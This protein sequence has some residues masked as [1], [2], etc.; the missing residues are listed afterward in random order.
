MGFSLTPAKMNR[1][2]KE[3]SRDNIIFAPKTMPGYGAFSDT[4]CVRYGEIASL[5]DI[6]F[7]EKSRFTFKEIL[8]PLSQTLFFFTEEEVKEADPPKKGA[9]V[10][11]RSCD[12]H[13]VKRLDEIYLKNGSPD[14]YY[15]RVRERMKFVLMGCPESFENCFCVDMQTNATDAYDAYIQ[16]G[17]DAVLVDNKNPDWEDALA[18]NAAGKEQVFPVF[19]GENRVRVNVPSAVGIEVMRSGMWTEYDSRCIACGRCNFSCPTCTCFTMQDVFYTD[20]GRVGERRRVAASCMVDGFSSVA[21]GG[22]YRREYGQRMR[23]K[24]LHKV[25]DFKKRFGYHMCV[26]CGRC[27]DVCPEYISFSGCIG[28]LESAMKE[29]AGNEQ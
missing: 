27:D 16:P 6:E 12:L 22:D 29:V 2:L 17:A 18:A 21:G 13:A 26:G 11:L 15:G 10:F 8:T 5:D 20:N 1:I 19:A 24:A 9:I 3:W 23:F 4:D 7:G 25:Y 28:K 14:Y